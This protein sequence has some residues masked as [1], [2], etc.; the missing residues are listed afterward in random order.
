VADQA[1]NGTEL[2]S[3]VDVVEFNWPLYVYKRRSR[4]GKEDLYTIAVW[5]GTTLMP[6]CH[7][8]P[9]ESALETL[10]NRLSSAGKTEVT[11][12]TNV[13]C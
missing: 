10:R 4:D 13:G 7:L 1:C 12:I 2:I 6:L 5:K 8:Q 9:L 3:Q 11:S